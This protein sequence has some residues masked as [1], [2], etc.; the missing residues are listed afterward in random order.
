MTSLYEDL[1]GRPVLEKII[2]DF[3]DV[4]VA[5]TM[6]G[7]LFK[8]VDVARLKQREVEFTARF[9]G[10]DIP[11][12]GRPLKKAHAPHPI[13][14]GQFDRRKQ[15]LKEAIQRHGVS[16]PIQRA[17]LRHVE[18]LRSQITKDAAGEC[19]DPDVQPRHR[20]HLVD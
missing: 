6:I 13:M 15:I 17:W 19:K 9:L 4:M 10:A 3:V 7:F 8:N 14:G 20:F 16:E 12:T 1:G 2:D 18:Q 11:Y 5:D